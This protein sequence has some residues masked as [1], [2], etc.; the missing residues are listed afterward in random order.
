[1]KGVFKESFYKFLKVKPDSWKE[2]NQYYDSN[3]DGSKIIRY[4]C[5]ETG[6]EYI[7][8]LKRHQPDFSIRFLSYV[9]PL[10]LK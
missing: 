9:D 5:E 8:F 10:K 2:F 1:M 6:K 7:V 3:G 4:G